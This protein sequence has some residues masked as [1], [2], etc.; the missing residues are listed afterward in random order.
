MA[1]K[2][3]PAKIN[4]CIWIIWTAPLSCAQRMPAVRCGQP[5][6]SLPPNQSTTPEMATVQLNGFSSA[7]VWFRSDSAAI[8]IYFSVLRFHRFRSVLFHEKTGSIVSGSIQTPEPNHGSKFL[9]GEKRKTTSFFSRNFCPLQSRP[10]SYQIFRFLRLLAWCLSHDPN[11]KK[12]LQ[13]VLTFLFL[14]RANKID[15]CLH[16]TYHRNWLSVI[17][18]RNTWRE[19]S[20][21][22]HQSGSGKRNSFKLR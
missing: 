3:T 20:F 11:T 12:G 1:Q 6:R 15:C 21:R 9:H 18:S 2:G 8:R 14:E 7:F 22:F 13:S 17:G 5:V 10:V 16:T 4:E 19:S